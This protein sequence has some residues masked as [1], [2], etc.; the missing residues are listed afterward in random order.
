MMWKLCDAYRRFAPPAGK[1]LPWI[2]FAYR[3]PIARFAP[4]EK[5]LGRDS[6]PD[7]GRKLQLGCYG[8]LHGR[9]HIAIGQSPKRRI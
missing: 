7:R 3:V 8:L 2:G 1:K 9:D 4:V 5:S 6:A